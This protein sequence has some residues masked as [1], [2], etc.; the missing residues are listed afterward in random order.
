MRKSTAR[1]V[2]LWGAADPGDREVPADRVDPEVPVNPEDRA[3]PAGVPAAETMKSRT[4]DCT[5]RNAEENIP[6]R[7][8][9]SVRTARDA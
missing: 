8:Q 1:A 5:A 3:D 4:T 6:T 2:L 7:T 9:R